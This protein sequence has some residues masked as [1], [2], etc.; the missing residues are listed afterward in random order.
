[1]EDLRHTVELVR[2]GSAA[3]ADALFALCWPVV[4]KAAYTITGNPGLAEDAAQDAIE[5]VFSRIRTFDSSRPL[6]PWVRRIAVNA[7]VDVLRRERRQP[8]SIAQAEDSQSEAAEGGVVTEA[9]A[10]LTE[11]KRLVIALHYWLDYS[12][13]Q[14]ARI[15]G[16]PVG[17]VAARL[18]RARAELRS[19]L[20]EQ[21]VRPA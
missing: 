9:V 13:E 18:S 21:H 20:E 1:V 15:L 10:A 7:A 17:T 19:R 8:V 6:E 11:E 5:R 4:W 12:I 16:E 2:R 14:I 3:A